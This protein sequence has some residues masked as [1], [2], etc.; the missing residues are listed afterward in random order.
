[1]KTV[2]EVTN[3]P[4][5]DSEMETETD[6]DVTE[7]DYKS[8]RLRNPKGLPKTKSTMNWNCLE[9]ENALIVR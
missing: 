8:L 4:V 5:P 7:I 6:M 3:T 9:N 2:D 1:M